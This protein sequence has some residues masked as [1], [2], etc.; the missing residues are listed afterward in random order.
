[1]ITVIN[2]TPVKELSDEQI[3]YTLTNNDINI[4]QL[5]YISYITQ[6]PNEIFLRKNQIIIPSITNKTENGIPVITIQ[7]F[8]K[9]SAKELKDTIDSLDKSN[10]I[11]IDLRA[12]T[13]GDFKEG[14]ESANLFIDGKE[15]LT[16]KDFKSDEKE[17]YTAKNGDIL[18]SAPIIII[19]DHSTKGIAEIFTSI[20]EGR[21]RAIIIGTPSF[22]NGTIAGKFDLSNNAQISIAT[23]EAFNTKGISPNKTGIIPLICSSSI[24]STND[25]EE[26]KTNIKDGFFKDNRPDATNKSSEI[27][28]NI[29]NSCKAIYFTKENNDIIIK[30]ATSLIKD[31]KAIQILQK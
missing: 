12:N 15:I 24:Y 10:G 22:G 17:T 11:I 13:N 18:N 16:T 27:I 28:D 3:E 9:G 25:I 1:M 4:I 29:R 26:L 14:I 5:K 30:L 31:K 8:K 20:L 6:I 7:N 21:N 19:V 23:K 2:N